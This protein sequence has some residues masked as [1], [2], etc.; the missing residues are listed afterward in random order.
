MMNWKDQKEQ[1]RTT[2]LKTQRTKEVMLG[3]PP[4]TATISFRMIDRALQCSI[5]VHSTNLYCDHVFENLLPGRPFIDSGAYGALSS[6]LSSMN[7]Q[8][9]IWG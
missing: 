6:E 5:C 2:N 3:L 7:F 4:S 8:G 9:H 1:A